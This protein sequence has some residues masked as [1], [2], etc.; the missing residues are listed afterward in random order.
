MP[1]DTFIPVPCPVKGLGD[2]RA[3][4]CGK[5]VVPMLLLFVVQPA[6]SLTAP[7]AHEEG[8]VV[9]AEAVPVQYMPG[10]LEGITEIASVAV[11]ELT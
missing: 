9:T 3:L 10:L 5:P 8:A 7:L 6:V 2:G 1:Q 4:G 11:I